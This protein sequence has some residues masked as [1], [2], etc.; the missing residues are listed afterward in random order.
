MAS[1]AS[2]GVVLRPDSRPCS[3]LTLCVAVDTGVT[4]MAFSFSQTRAVSG[5]AG[6]R[7]FVCGHD[8]YTTVR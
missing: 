3:L 1:S 7:L 6:H 8:M 5:V 4:G 2:L